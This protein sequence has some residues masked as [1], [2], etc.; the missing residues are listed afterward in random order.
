MER[1]EHQHI[2]LPKREERQNEGEDRG[3]EG[4]D[5]GLTNQGEGKLP[6]AKVVCVRS[7]EYSD[8]K[9]GSVHGI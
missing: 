7:G 8:I 5:G 6:S 3:R 2:G 4:G 9:V 1:D